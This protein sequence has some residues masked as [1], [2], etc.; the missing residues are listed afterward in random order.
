M[1]LI[2]VFLI[3]TLLSMWLIFNKFD[4]NPREFYKVYVNPSLF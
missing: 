1:F 3:K 4:G 2:N